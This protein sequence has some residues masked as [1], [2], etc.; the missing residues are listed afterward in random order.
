M[1]LD[2][3]GVKFQP[4]LLVD[5]EFLH[6]FPLITLQL[7]H[8]AHLGVV[9]NGAI[10]SE[11]LLDDLE[12]LLLIKFLGKT[13]DCRQSLTTIALCSLQSACLSRKCGS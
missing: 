2:G 6:I 1:Y 13:L 10:A 12:N 3:L 7:D 9:D 11:F 8:L 5:Q 4:F